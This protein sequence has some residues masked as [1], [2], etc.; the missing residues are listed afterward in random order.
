MMAIAIAMPTFAQFDGSRNTKNRF[1][2][3]NVEQYYGVRL[4]YNLA[5]INSS[6]AT[7]DMNSYGGF[8]FGAI[9]TRSRSASSALSCASFADMIPSCSPSSLI[10]LTS[11]SRI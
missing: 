7:V 8:A 10:N 11:R 5:T 2:H 1:N 6:D 4:G 9:I 3:S